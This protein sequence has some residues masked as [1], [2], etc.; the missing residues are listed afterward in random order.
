MNGTECIQL[1]RQAQRAAKTRKRK[2]S[3]ELQGVQGEKRRQ[4]LK[5]LD[6]PRW[7]SRQNETPDFF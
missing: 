3:H 7:Q 1:K 6:S 5:E 2:A 4:K